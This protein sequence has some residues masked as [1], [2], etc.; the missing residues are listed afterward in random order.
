MSNSMAMWM[1]LLQTQPFLN[2]RWM[3]EFLANMSHSI[4]PATWKRYCISIY[5]GENGIQQLGGTKTHGSYGDQCGCVWDLLFEKNIITCSAV[6]VCVSLCPFVFRNPFYII[7]VGNMWNTGQENHRSQFPFSRSTQ[8]S[9]C[10]S[11]PASP[12][13][14]YRKSVMAQRRHAHSL[15]MCVLQHCPGAIHLRNQK[16]IS[17][18]T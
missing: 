15:H 18:G 7:H 14:C 4:A 2:N 8:H 3:S 13:E 1:L 16:Q 17:L 12:A 9:I 11:F 5:R 10:K 6:C